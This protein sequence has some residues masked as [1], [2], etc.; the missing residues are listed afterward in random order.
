M[1]KA[2]VHLLVCIPHFQTKNL[3]E[4]ILCHGII[5]LHFRCNKEMNLI[6]IC[7]V[8]EKIEK[9]KYRLY[10]LFIYFFLFEIRPKREQDL[11]C[12]FEFIILSARVYLLC[13][14]GSSSESG[15]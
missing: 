11:G 14:Y 8:E 15:A 2:N 3:S 5:M 6:K 9:V 12:V 13:E 4:C 1:H 7:S 10:R